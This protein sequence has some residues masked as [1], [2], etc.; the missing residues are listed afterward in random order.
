M[1]AIEENI[2]LNISSEFVLDKWKD[3]G[4]HV[5]TVVKKGLYA[6]EQIEEPHNWISV[7]PDA[8]SALRDPHESAAGSLA[9]AQ[10]VV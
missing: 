9:A 6:I 5:P 7:S 2:V 4:L 10:P 8:Q 3:V 1:E